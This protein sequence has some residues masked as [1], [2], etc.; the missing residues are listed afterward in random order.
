MPDMN[1]HMVEAIQTSKQW[2][3]NHPEDKPLRLSEAFYLS[4]KASGEVFGKVGSFEEG[5]EFD[6][7]IIDTSEFGEAKTIPEQL[8]KYI[9]CGDD[10]NIK[11]RFVSGREIQRPFSYNN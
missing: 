1:R 2:W 4:T 9:Y 10:R 11:H 5:Y 3:V 8:E 6:A 7:L